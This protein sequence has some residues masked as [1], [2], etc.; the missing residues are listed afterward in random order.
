MTFSKAKILAALETDNCLTV[1]EGTLRDD[2]LVAAFVPVL[3]ALNPKSWLFKRA[4]YLARRADETEEDTRAN[5][6]IDAINDVAPEGY[7]FG[8]HEGDGACFGFWE[9]EERAA[10]REWTAFEQ[11]LSDIHASELPSLRTPRKV[12]LCGEAPA[13]RFL[14][15]AFGP[16]GT[17]VAVGFEPVRGHAACV[18]GMASGLDFD[19]ALEIAAEK[20][21]EVAPGLFTEPDYKETCREYNVDFEAFKAARNPYDDFHAVV[22]EAE[23]DLTHTESGWLL[24]H[25]WTIVGTMSREKLLAFARGE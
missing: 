14:V 5:D 16:Y 3:R 8:A 21:L 4:E 11:E 2:D 25:E 7:T 12:H 15:F 9:T 18:H 20:L 24:S 17:Y 19:D 22:D 1:S 10:E 23:A 6:L 13:E